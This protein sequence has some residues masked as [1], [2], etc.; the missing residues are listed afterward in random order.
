[1]RDVEIE[2]GEYQ[3]DRAARRA[4]AVLAAAMMAGG[5]R[6]MEAF[7]MP[8]PDGLLWGEKRT[9]RQDPDHPAREGGARDDKQEGTEPVG[10]AGVDGA[11]GNGMAEGT[12][13]KGTAV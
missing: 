13:G 5:T 1:M 8:G 3:N 10:N 6:Q 4:M 2:L 9:A 7:M 11:D 12:G